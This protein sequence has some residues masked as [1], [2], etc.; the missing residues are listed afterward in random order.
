MIVP[1]AGLRSAMISLRGSWSVI[2][3]LRSMTL[4]NMMPVIIRRPGTGLFRHP[5]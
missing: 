2:I 3:A 4:M 1:A 5:C